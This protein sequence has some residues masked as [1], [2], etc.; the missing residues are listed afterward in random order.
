M[1]SGENALIH[2][3]IGL[4]VRVLKSSCRTMERTCGKIIDETK[5]TVVIEGSGGAI[6]TLP[7]KSCVFELEVKKGHWIRIRGDSACYSPEDRLKKIFRKL[8]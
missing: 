3:W 4:N 6:L 2:E 1:I 8:A 7:K 5:N